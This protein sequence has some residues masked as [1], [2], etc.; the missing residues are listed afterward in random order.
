MHS[1]QHQTSPKTCVITCGLL[2]WLP[3]AAHA[4]IIGVNFTDPPQ[5]P[6]YTFDVNLAAKDFAGVVPSKNFNN[7]PG[8]LGTSSAL[9]DDSG[10]VT[11]ATVTLAGANGYAYHS[12]SGL[13][14]APGDETLNQSYFYATDSL[15][16]SLNNIPFANYDVY[17]Y[18]V[19]DHDGG[20]SVSDGTTTYYVDGQGGYAKIDGSSSTPYVYNQAVSTVSSSPTPNSDYERF[21]GLSGANQTFTF[22]K[23][24]DAPY[25]NGFQIVNTS[26]APV[27]EPSTW[28][29]MFVGVMS[30]SVY[31]WRRKQG[32]ES[33]SVLVRPKD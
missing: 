12:Q 30:L 16:V 7:I 11:S 24:G 20:E 6:F 22:E 29:L 9:Q 1:F 26:V 19:N 15:S 25:V 13:Q 3:L 17:F 14:P 32:Q 10:N 2:L 8:F 33:S 27:P 21:S 28:A 23:P 31:S 4:S 18:T 5:V